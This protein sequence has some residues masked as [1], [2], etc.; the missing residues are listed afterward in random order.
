MET[1]THDEV[2][3]DRDRD[4]SADGMRDARIVVHDD[5][6]KH[7][8]ISLV[9]PLLQIFLIAVA[10]AARLTFDDASQSWRN[11]CTNK[12]PTWLD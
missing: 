9:L 7:L 3:V 12:T 1:H 8:R 10:M 5:P 6:R 2:A 4:H 11:T